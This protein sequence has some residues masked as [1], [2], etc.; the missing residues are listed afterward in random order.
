VAEGVKQ[1]LKEQPREEIN[2]AVRQAYRNVLFL[3]FLYQQVN[4]K[5]FSE[6]RYY[7]T[8]WLLLSKELKSLLREQALDRHMRWNRIMV[9]IEMPYPLDSETAAAAAAA[10][11]HHVFTWEVLEESDDLHRWLIETY[12]AEGKMALPD[13]A[14][15]MLSGAK[16]LY[17]KVP[18]EAEVKELFQDAESFQ[19]FL[20]GEDY[21]YGLANVPDAEYDA[22]YEAIVIAIKSLIQ[23]GTVVDLPTIPHAFLKEVSLFDGDWI[24]SYIVELAE[25]GARFG[26]EGLP[27]GGTQRQSPDGL[28]TDHRPEGPV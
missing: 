21:S 18:T 2:R 23:P 20:D 12:L 4:G 16:L 3:F 13:G 7:W 1:T 27:A 24:D 10:Q 14:Y 15:E 25:W 6:N 19:R 11:Q 22:H 5:L 8:L 9:G 26:R 17:S 28:A